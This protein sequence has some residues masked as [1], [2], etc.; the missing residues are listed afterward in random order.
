MITTTTNGV[1]ISV[2]QLF[3]ND[4][5]D[6]RNNVFLF[7][8]TI[9]IENQNDFAI[10]LK[11][12]YWVIIDSLASKRKVQGAGVIGEQ[13]IIEPGEVFVYS[14]ACD[15]ASELGFMEGFYLFSKHPDMGEEPFKVEVPRFKLEYP[16]KLN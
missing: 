1:K 12:R 15:L 8:Y 6:I 5:S 4:Q 13:P 14:S 16:Y 11:R 7:N 2:K 9:N 3:R 10:Q